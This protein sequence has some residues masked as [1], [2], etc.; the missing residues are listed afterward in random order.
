MKYEELT[1]EQIQEAMKAGSPEDMKAYLAQ[2]GVEIPAKAPWK[3][4]EKTAK[5]G[6]KLWNT[7]MIKPIE[8]CPEGEHDFQPTGKCEMERTPATE[9]GSSFRRE[10]ACTKCP[11]VKWVSDVTLPE[12]VEA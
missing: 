8:K 7:M 2:E 5:L 11:A 12:A 10:Y 6:L 1:A 3:M 4:S 9:P